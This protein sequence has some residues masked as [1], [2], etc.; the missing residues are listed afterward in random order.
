MLT[1]HRDSSLMIEAAIPQLVDCFALCY[2]ITSIQLYLCF[3]LNKNIFTT[4]MILGINSRGVAGAIGQPIWQFQVHIVKIM[5]N[6]IPQFITHGFKF[7]VK[8]AKLLLFERI[9]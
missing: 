1:R 5:I 4:E 2:F 7:T 3:Y 8:I 9:Q 6:I